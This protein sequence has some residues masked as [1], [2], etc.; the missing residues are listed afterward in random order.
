MTNL[1]NESKD[2]L[3]SLVRIYEYRVHKLERELQEARDT[4]F[5]KE[6]RNSNKGNR[7]KSTK[8]A[9]E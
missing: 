7:K 3:V 4:W 8:D 9:N 5:V 1:E 2:K 6:A